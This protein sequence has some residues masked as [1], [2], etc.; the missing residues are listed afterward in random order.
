M[1]EVRTLTVPGNARPWLDA[2]VT[3]AEGDEVTLLASGQVYVS[4][5][6]GL[7]LLPRVVLWARVGGANVFRPG[8]DSASFRSASHGPLQLATLQGRWATPRG[9]HPAPQAYDAIEGALEVTVV[10]WATAASVGVAALA[11]FAP[12][13]PLIAGEHARI[14]AA[15]VLPR[16]FEPLWWVGS[17]DNF[18]EVTLDGAPAIALRSELN[19]GI[20]RA[21]IDLPLAAG[22]TVDWEW[23]VNQLPSVRAEDNALSHQYASLAVELD[24]GQD[25]SWY[26]S[27]T[28]A[29]EHHYRCPFPS[30]PGET[31]LVVRSG[32]AD[33]GRWVRERRD[34][35]KDVAAA[36]VKEP[37]RITGIWLIASTMFGTR[38]A[39]VDFRRIVVTDA[40]GTRHV[41]G[42]A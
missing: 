35:A 38:P 5:L 16:G 14:R 8:S 29:P 42:G 18:A 34:V 9:D 12:D 10:R 37:A 11:A 40:Q 4:R 1:R 21:P 13:D 15:R 3:L 24:D 31:H 36:L 27:A 20:L 6:L 32:D 41:I 25:L 17:G 23:R 22:I 26:W 30:W 2:G 39:S 7:S 28:L 19:G 33:Q